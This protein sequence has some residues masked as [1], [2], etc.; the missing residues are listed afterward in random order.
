MSVEA[1]TD[2]PTNDPSVDGVMKA[3]VYHGPGPD[4][5]GRR[6]PSRRFVSTFADAAKTSALKVVLNLPRGDHARQH[7]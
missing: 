7:P 1:L 3:L 6:N 5:R 2:R 4:E